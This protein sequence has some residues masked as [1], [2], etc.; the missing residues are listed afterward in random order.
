MLPESV[1]CS[2]WIDDDFVI[3]TGVCLLQTIY[4]LSKMHNY[5]EGCVK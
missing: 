3:I 1:V 4:S 5:F 2:E